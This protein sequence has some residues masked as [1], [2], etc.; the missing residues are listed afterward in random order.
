M[1]TSLSNIN[2]YNV[3]IRGKQS[4]R[5]NIQ[6]KIAE[7]YQMWFKK[8]TH[9]GSSKHSNKTNTK[10]I[11]TQSHDGKML[12]D[13]IVKEARENNWQQGNS[14]KINN[15]LSKTVRPERAE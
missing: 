6:G 9:P 1:W 15:W 7:T 2:R 5:K 10:I 12:K 8:S 14:N 4:I 3:I 11:H 13:K